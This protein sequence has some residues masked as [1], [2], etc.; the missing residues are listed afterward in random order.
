MKKKNNNKRTKIILAYS[1]G[2]DTSVICK[3]L[4]LKGYEV[5]CFV[6][7]VGQREDFQALKK[8]ALLSG[9]SKVYVSDIREEFVKNYVYPSIAFQALYEGRYLLGTSL[10]RPVIMKEMIRITKSEKA[11]II[12]HGATGKGN[13]QVRFEISAYALMP[14]VQIIAPWRVK[15][16]NKLMPGRKEAITFAK[17]HGIPVKATTA[18]PWSS[19]ENLLHISF[20]AGMLENPNQ[21]PREDMFEY[22][23]S[24]LKAK[25]RIEKLSIEFEKGIPIKINN[26]KYSA[27]QILENLNDY[28][29]RNGIGRIDIVESRFI[30]M[31]SRG[32][33]ETPAGTI[34][35]YAHLDLETLTTDR[36]VISLKNTLSLTFAEK[37][38]NGFWFAPEMDCLLKFLQES[39]KRVTGKVHLELYKGNITV[40][41]RESKFSLYDEKVASMEDDGGTY[42]QQDAE[43]FIKLNALRLIKK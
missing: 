19:D 12:A 8:K 41:G 38:Y 32:V 34:L 3:W 29:G 4:Q 37:V 11:K 6:A 2:L 20:E 27:V 18:K 9:A 15:E 16:F 14:K 25:N 40:V 28:G 43:G 10:A 26:K 30:G 33:Y 17:K 39:Q 1:G 22:S 23:T 31:K 13:D 5:I 7:N 24:P 21:K 36:E 35:F 42:N